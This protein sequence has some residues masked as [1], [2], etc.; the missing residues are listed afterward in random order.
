MMLPNSNLPKLGIIAG[1]GDLPL[2]VIQ[3]CLQDRREFFVIA[4]KDQTD[5]A[6]VDAIPHQWI[7][8]G[9]SGKALKKLKEQNVSELV[10]V[11]SVS[12]PTFSSVGLDLW[13]TKFLVKAGAAALGDDGLLGALVREIEK[14][15]FRVVGVEEIM[16]SLI[17]PAG[18]YGKHAPDEQ[19]LADIRRGVEVARGIGALDVGQ[20]AVVQEGLVLGVE[21]IEGTDR[22]LERCKDLKRDG[23]GGVLVKLKKPDQETRADLPTVGVETLRQAVDAGLRGIAI[24]AGNTLVVDRENVIAEADKAGLFVIGIDVEN[25]T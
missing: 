24:E 8:L 14:E 6:T 3:A 10:M 23:P 4:L 25:E 15:G 20:G 1:G 5:P 17:A 13:T 21:A 12:R 11:G 2:Q 7:P 18:V 16:P 19:A 9:K 22:L